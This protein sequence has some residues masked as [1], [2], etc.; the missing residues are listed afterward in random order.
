VNLSTGRVLI[1]VALIVAGLAVL[2]NGF[3]DSGPTVAATPTGS[4]SVGRIST[5]TQP[6]ASSTSSPTPTQTPAPNKTGVPF[7]ALNG[8]DVPGAGAAAQTMLT[9][10]GYDSVATAADV[11]N[12]PVPKTTIYF[13]P[14][15]SGQNEAD[16]TYV[17]KKYFD[18]SSVK[19]LNTEIQGVVP[20]EAAIV[21]VVGVDWATKITS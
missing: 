15:H 10:D 16:A 1:I 5:E 17:S 3:A 11:V 19:K 18:G 2:A 6:P 8:T 14:D 21:V 9:Q 7:M 20:D 4:P 13:R 12:K